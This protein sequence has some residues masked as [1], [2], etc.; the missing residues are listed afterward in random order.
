[1]YVGK[2]LN[3]FKKAKVAHILI[4]A[5]SVNKNDELII[6]GETTGVVEIKLENIFCNDEPS[7]K[8]V[9]GDEITFQCDKLVRARDKV[10]VVRKVNIEETIS[11]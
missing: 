8:A 5:G 4:E 9:K 1:M 7:M 11:N 6:M 10:Y 3:Y 2:V